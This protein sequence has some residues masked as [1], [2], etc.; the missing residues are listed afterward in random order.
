MTVT[1]STAPHPPLARTHQLELQAPGHPHSPPIQVHGAGV[2]GARGCSSLPGG[3]GTVGGGGIPAHPC[4]R[5][6][7]RHLHICWPRP[8]RYANPIPCSDYHPPS[9][10]LQWEGRWAPSPI[11]IPLKLDLLSGS[12]RTPPRPLP[13]LP[14]PS[15][16]SSYAQDP[17][18]LARTSFF[19]HP[20]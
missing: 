14:P 11:P 13:P 7:Q 16:F 20:L 15:H 19:L 9:S 6:V 3:A 2:S 18:F 5:P 8:C 1:A 12:L 10:G 4:G 17:H